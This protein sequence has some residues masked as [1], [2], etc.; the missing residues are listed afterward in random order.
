MTR[1]GVLLAL[2]VATAACTADPI[3][4]TPTETTAPAA[5]AAPSASPSPV[6]TPPTPTPTRVPETCSIVR[7][8]PATW[9]VAG[10]AK[11]LALI[12]RSPL[13]TSEAPRYT[14]WA[15]QSLDAPERVAP[16]AAACGSAE[17]AGHTW[18]GGELTIY[19]AARDG[20]YRHHLYAIT[21]RTGKVEVVLDVGDLPL[22]GVAPDGRIAYYRSP[23]IREFNPETNADRLLGTP[24]RIAAKGP[25]LWAPDSR[26]V[27]FPEVPVGVT[28]QAY[29]G[30]DSWSVMPVT[31]EPTAPRGTTGETI[32]S[33]APT[34]DRVCAASGSDYKMHLLDVRSNREVIP[35]TRPDGRVSRPLQMIGCSWSQDGVL[36]TTFSN[37]G[38]SQ[39][40]LID[41]KI[42]AFYSS[43]LR[44]LA[45][46][47]VGGVSGRWTNRSQQ[48]FVSQGPGYSQPTAFLSIDGSVEP[49]DP[50]IGPTVVAVLS[51]P[52][53]R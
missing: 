41:P 6:P 32:V 53:R 15:L 37:T 14:E 10:G 29:D 13:D 52:P 5:S 45:H 34:G 33:W 20:S 26:Y 31:D 27:A 16:L 17:F 9:A 43:D 1:I 12:Q 51:E 46:F 30:G 36:A 40:Q 3:A 39:T 42:V 48:V 23:G 28:G 18:L 25:L 21:P 24:R 38:V 49:A 35:S 2:L 8:A 22:V 4:T 50:R 47:E 7:A 19:L 44:E 11:G